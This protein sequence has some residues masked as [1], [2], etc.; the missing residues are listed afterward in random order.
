MASHSSIPACRITRTVK[1]GGI[2]SIGSQRV[3]HSWA[4]YTQSLKSL[5]SQNNN[6]NNNN[7]TPKTKKLWFPKE[8]YLCQDC[9][10]G[11]LPEFPAC[12]PVLQILKFARPIN[13]GANSLKS[14]CLCL[15]LC[16]YLCTSAH[17]YILLNLLLQRISTDTKLLYMWGNKTKQKTWKNVKCFPYLCIFETCGLLGSSVS[18]LAE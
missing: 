17:I 2:Q 16:I 8:G 10:I 14:L 11:I 4:T 7:K 1:P 15:S 3:R 13:T 12:W 9:D 6:N 18:V 5:K